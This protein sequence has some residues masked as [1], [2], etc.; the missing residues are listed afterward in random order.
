MRGLDDDL[1]IFLGQG[2]E[3]KALSKS[4]G[5]ELMLP[6]KCSD[7]D[8]QASTTSEMADHRGAASDVFVRIEVVEP[9]EAVPRPPRKV[10]VSDARG[11]AQRGAWIAMFIGVDGSDS[12]FGVRCRTPGT[13]WQKCVDQ[14]YYTESSTHDSVHMHTHVLTYPDASYALALSSHHWHGPWYAAF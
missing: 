11:G 5:G 8:Q 14:L 1:E 9:N 7:K 10:A 4:L 3:H 6:S 12:N 13:G 2:C